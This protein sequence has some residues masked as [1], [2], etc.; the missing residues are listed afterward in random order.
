M[1]V[2]LLGVLA[3]TSLA[4]A[5]IGSPGEIR[6]AQSL[7]GDHLVVPKTVS[8]SAGTIHDVNRLAGGMSSSDWDHTDRA[9]CD[10]HHWHWYT[11][12]SRCHRNVLPL[13]FIGAAATGGFIYAMT[14]RD[15]SGS[16]SSGQTPISH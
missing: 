8:A 2:S 9:Q 1:T 5:S 7:S 6:S 13:A 3:A 14:S 16:G 15:E 11:K 10:M 4:A 12:A